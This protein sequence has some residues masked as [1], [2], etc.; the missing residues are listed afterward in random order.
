MV[1]QN[2]TDAP[3]HFIVITLNHKNL[4]LRTLP[5][6]SFE[7]SELS[8]FLTN[9][10]DNASIVEIAG[11]CTCNRTEFFV[12]VHSVKDAAHAIV[13]EIAHHSGASLES[14]REGLDVLV[15]A[16][17]VEH[18]FRMVS[19]MES[20]VVGDAQIM[21]QVKEAYEH[22]LSLNTTSK[23][24]NIL[25]QRAFAAA[26]RIRH[27]TGLGKGK[28]SIAALAVDY[29]KQH[30]GALDDITATVIGVGKMGALTAKYIQEANVKELRIINRSRRKSV[31]LIETVDGIIY[32]FDE[33]ETVVAESDMVISAT[34]A[35][36]KLITKSMLD[37]EEF[38]HGKNRL[39]IDIALPP[40]IDPAI[41]ELDGVKLVDLDSL[42][43]IAHKNQDLRS[44]QIE[45]AEQILKDELEELGPWPLP[46]HIDDLAQEL[47]KFAGAICQEEIQ[48]ILKLLPDLSEE[49]CDAIKTRMYRLTERIILTPRRNLR[50]N[51]TMRTCPNAAQC[52]ADLFA[53]ECGA[54]HSP[55]SEAGNN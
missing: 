31:E 55:D 27:E 53:V 10:H 28:V 20:M 54:R 36:N 34:T 49:Q 37:N 2:N 42:R 17:A 1:V 5:D 30:F 32:D 25:F 43:E 18:F 7:L 21:G 12:A 15:D 29:A 8:H 45:L 23:V 51:K 41:G 46:F 50:Q 4:S 3:A 39:F 24:F 47:G 13:H 9:L 11:L 38:N 40:D 33:L 26:K 52:L 19:S 16:Q 6:F 48:E 35:P 44:S 14:I 22:A